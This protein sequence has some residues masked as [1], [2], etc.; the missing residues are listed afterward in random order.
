MCKKSTLIVAAAIS[1]LGLSSQ[2]FAQ[3]F[4]TSNGTGRE[5][6]SRYRSDGGRHAGN[7]TGHDALTTVSVTTGLAQAVSCSDQIAELRHAA[8]RNHQ[9]MPETAWQAESYAQLMFAADLALAEA[10]D[11]LGRNDECLFS[12]RRAKEELQEQPVYTVKEN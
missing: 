1:V 2:A 5:L 12:A 10:Q 4:S 8:L 11:A 3:S 6:P 7:G 9:P